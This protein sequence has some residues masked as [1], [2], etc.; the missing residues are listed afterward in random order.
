MSTKQFKSMRRAV[1]AVGFHPRDVKLVDVKPVFIRGISL[2][3]PA[4]GA[5]FLG[6][7]II[8]PNC[9]RGLYKK[10]KKAERRGELAQFL[11]ANAA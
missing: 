7:R 3:P 9:G 6:Q 1:R 8:Q 2:F 4:P 10:L 11:A 5:I